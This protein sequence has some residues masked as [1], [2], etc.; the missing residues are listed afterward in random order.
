MNRQK[1][2]K[3][4]RRIYD[5]LAEEGYAVSQHTPKQIFEIFDSSSL[6]GLVL[7]I[8]SGCCVHSSYLKEEGFDVIA[9]DVS[10]VALSRAK[11][12]LDRVCADAE[13]LPFR[14]DMFEGILC[15]EVF[16]HL[17]MPQKCLEEAYRV[18]KKRRHLPIYNADFQF[19]IDQIAIFSKEAEN[20]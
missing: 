3:G 19:S 9:I 14:D 11:A 2:I 8:G 12:K 18:L 1:V 5:E 10:A 15:V 13:Q 7:D 16:E 6:K 20:L 4:I 17:P